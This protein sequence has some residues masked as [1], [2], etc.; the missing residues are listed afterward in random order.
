VLG[1]VAPSPPT[2]LPRFTGARGGLCAFCREKA[3]WH[4]SPLVR[5]EGTGVRGDTTLFL[6]PHGYFADSWSHAKPRSR[7]EGERRG[8]PSLRFVPGISWRFCTANER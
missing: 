5:G 1:S 2:P 6:L 4:P 8:L 7:E 3:Q